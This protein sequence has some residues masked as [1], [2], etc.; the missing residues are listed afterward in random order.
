MASGEPAD[1]WA[2]RDHPIEE[3][4][5]FQRKSWIVER[6]GW[7]AM[8]FVV[9]LALL[10]IFSDG[11][12]SHATAQS[13]NGNLRVAYQRFQRNDAATELRIVAPSG[14][15]ESV[16]IVLDRAFADSFT[17]EHLTPLPAAS[18]GSAERLELIYHAPGGVPVEVALTVRPRTIGLLR[19]RILSGDAQVEFTQLIYP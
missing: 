8:A 17:I 14:G 18:A 9:V 12:L 19:G 3:C 7:A 6:I 5:A 16:L 10:G 1:P 13:A 11:P 4:M 2:D 15:S